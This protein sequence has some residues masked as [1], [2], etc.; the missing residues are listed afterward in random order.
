MPT[1]GYL[2]NKYQRT[3]GSKTGLLQKR[4]A[5]EGDISAKKYAA[6]QKKLVQGINI[7]GTVGA[8]LAEY[9]TAKKGGY[10]GGLMGY[11]GEKAKEHYGLDDGTTTTTMVGGKTITERS[12]G[13]T[14][15]VATDYRAAFDTG[16]D[17]RKDAAGEWWENVKGL[18]PKS[19][20]ESKVGKH[21]RSEGK[22]FLKKSLG[23]GK[24]KGG[25]TLQTGESPVSSAQQQYNTE[26]Q[27]R[28]KEY[29]GHTLFSQTFGEQS[30]VTTDKPATTHA[31]DL[32]K[33]LGQK[34]GG[35]F[36]DERRTTGPYNLRTRYSPDYQ[37]DFR[38]NEEFLEAYM[39]A[40]GGLNDSLLQAPMN[41]RRK[42][43]KKLGVFNWGRE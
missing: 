13:G 11:L 21:W 37:G 20:G 10:E 41:S 14:G 40:G 35:S 42:P 12:S 5:I 25:A 3:L 17:K 33:L 39:E 38:T 23:I 34:E 26:K 29:Q 22:D 43:G 18:V 19:I 2:L 1:P 32:A 8:G 6:D 4:L 16:V 9:S 28:L 7:V 31:E 27:S 15:V 30:G 36:G 24:P